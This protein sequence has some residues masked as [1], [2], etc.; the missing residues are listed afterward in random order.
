VFSAFSSNSTYGVMIFTLLATLV[1]A[2][3]MGN[4]H[5]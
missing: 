3:V 4:W 1:S 5:A 2:L